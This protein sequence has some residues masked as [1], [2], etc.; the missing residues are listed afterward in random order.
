MS[1]TQTD[2]QALPSLLSWDGASF[3]FDGKREFLVSGEIHYARAPREQWASLLDQSRALGLNC[4]AAYIFWGFHE[5]SRDVYDFSG[6]RDLGYFL[7]LCAER[8]LRVMLRVGP[9]CC[10]EWNYGGFPAYLRD[11][12][13]VT[14]RTWNAPYMERVEK[15]F[16]HLFAEFTPYL[17]SKGGPVALVQ[18]ENEYANVGARYG[19]AG[20]RYN[21]WMAEL[22]RDLGVDVPLIMCETGAEIPGV[23]TTANGFSIPAEKIDA[24]CKSQPGVPVF[25]TELW[26]GWYNTWGFQQHIRDPRNIAFHLL[27]FIGNGGSGWNY[28]MWYGG[29]NFGRTS[30]YLQ[31][32]SYDFG[33]PVDEHGGVTLK[34]AF[35]SKLHQVLKSVEETVLGG[36]VERNPNRVVW[37]KGGRSIVLERNS[38][39]FKAR[40]VDGKGCVLFD[41]AETFKEVEAS[42]TTS[43]WEGLASLGNWRCWLEP[44]PSQRHGGIQSEVPVEQLSLT[45]DASDY[46]W[47]SAQLTVETAGEQNVTISHGGDVFT[48]F[49][50]GVPVGRSQPPFLE[51]RGP[52]T[53]AEAAPMAGGVYAVNPLEVIKG[54]YFQTFVFSA[55]KGTHRLEI[56]AASLGLIKGDW[57]VSGPMETERKGIW[58]SVSHNGKEISHWEMHPS[59]EG[60][61]LGV[62]TQ[63]DSVSWQEAGKARACAWYETSFTVPS[64]CLLPENHFRLDAQGLGKGMLF[65]NGRALGRHWLIEGHGYGADKTWHNVE[66]DGLSLGPEGE[67]TQRFY[68]IPAAWLKPCNRLVLFEEQETAVLTDL[69]VQLQRR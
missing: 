43:A 49:L 42:F 26:P 58:G 6:D 25:W 5:T 55:E 33:G 69:T 24:L 57:M 62:M 68:R 20:V 41:S 22:T 53:T 3:I 65:L 36:T 34:G 61:R 29:T 51:N 11:E 66:L 4:V 52:T 14:F 60:E 7:Q 59:L 27:D 50:D 39:T 67:P 23:I 47:Y 32:T 8:G 56:L 10:A 38:S 12:A 64:E 1:Q 9:Y 2:P 45:K 37:S 19:E 40:L 35:L 16:R 48:V 63:A 54:Q 44:L 15:F 46:T 18:V 30:M 31:T 17:A 21:I 28:Y 13:G